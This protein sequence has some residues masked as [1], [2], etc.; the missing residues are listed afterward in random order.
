MVLRL[1]QNAGR[2]GQVME[3]FGEIIAF[4]AGLG[5]GITIGSLVKIKISKA[6]SSGSISGGGRSVNQSGARAKGDI[7][8]GDKNGS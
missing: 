2:T 4:I 8:G 1:S 5:G 3:Y 6:S 7:V